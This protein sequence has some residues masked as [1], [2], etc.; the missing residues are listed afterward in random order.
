MR[1]TW[2]RQAPKPLGRGINIRRPSAINTHPK[3]PRYR[4]RPLLIEPAIVPATTSPLPTPLSSTAQDTG[5]TG[6][7]HASVLTQPRSGSWWY[8]CCNDD[9][10]QAKGTVSSSTKHTGHTS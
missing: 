1:K 4:K 2:V 10:T 3:A 9:D 6:K 7:V 8:H 5:A